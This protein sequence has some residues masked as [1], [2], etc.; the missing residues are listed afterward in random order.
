VRAGGN[1]R[2]FERQPV[3]DDVEKAAD[4]R[5]EKRRAK[6]K[7]PRK[8]GGKGG[9]I[10]IHAGCEKARMSGSPVRSQKNPPGQG[11]EDQISLSER[12][13]KRV[14]VLLPR[15]PQAGVQ[16]GRVGPGREQAHLDIAHLRCAKAS[17]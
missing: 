9:E 6:G 14:P 3:D 15:I 8:F 16:S 17:L 4:D 5:A 13:A 11:P 1:D 12:A 2:F 10:V 7:K